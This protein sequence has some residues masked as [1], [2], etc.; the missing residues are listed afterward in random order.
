[1]W[2]MRRPDC[3]K[4]AWDGYAG[5]AVAVFPCGDEAIENRSAAGSPKSYRLERYP[6]RPPLSLFLAP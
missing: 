4:P 1:M 2:S 5:T 3:R 6:P